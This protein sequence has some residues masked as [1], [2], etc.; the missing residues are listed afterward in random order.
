MPKV[1]RFLAVTLALVVA[2][3]AATAVYALSGLV[4]TVLA[5]VIP[6]RVASLSLGVFALV[7]VITPS[8]FAGVACFR[9][10][11][12]RLKAAAFVSELWTACGRAY[13]SAAL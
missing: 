11:H 7:L 12:S 3:C 9:W 10:T 1:A 13:S 6:T 2:C 8:I 5:S 4:V